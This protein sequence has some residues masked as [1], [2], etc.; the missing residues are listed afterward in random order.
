MPIALLRL[1]CAFSAC[2][3]GGAPAREYVIGHIEADGPVWNI[4]RD[5]VAVLDQRNQPAFRRFWR[6]MANREPGG[7]AGKAA[8][9]D[10]RARFSKTLR[11]DVARRIE[12]LLHART[13]ARAFVADHH[14]VTG[15]DFSAENA[16][17]RGVLTFEHTGP[18][19]KIEDARVNTRGLHDAAVLGQISI[20]NGEPSI[21]AEGV[22]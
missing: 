11:F 10:K 2:L 17:D 9:G 21:L 1:P 22:V 7:A 13:A 14:D 8:V 16:C 5:A 3:H 18:A 19:G 4:D 12:H 15:A 6:H 20:E